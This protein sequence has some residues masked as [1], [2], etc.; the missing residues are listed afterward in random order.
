MYSPDSWPLNEKSD[1]WAVGLV[2]HRL[3]W[4]GKGNDHFNN[5]HLTQLNE[6]VGYR[7]QGWLDTFENAGL[8]HNLGSFVDKTSPYH[9]VHNNDLS[10]SD[11]DF[12]VAAYDLTNHEG[13]YSIELINFIHDCLNYHPD[14]RPDLYTMKSTIDTAISRLDELYGDE[15]RKPRERTAMGHTVLVE[16]ER[17]SAF[18][19]GQQ[20]EPPRK[21]R[22]VSVDPLTNIAGHDYNKHV[23]AWSDVSNYPRP[24]PE[25]QAEAIQAIEDFL[26]L[27]RNSH[28]FDED[29]KLRYCFQYLR[30]C[31]FQRVAPDAPTHVVTTWHAELT[32]SFTLY[33][34]KELLRLIRGYVIPRLLEKDDSPIE[35]RDAL[36]VL[37]HAAQWGG[38]LLDLD[39]EPKSPVLDDKTELHRGFRDW[40]MIDPFDKNRV[41]SDS[42]LQ[43][44]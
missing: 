26:N 20:Y 38:F 6:H 5:C 27:K 11:E 33:A 40:V 3:L 23:A 41:P 22:K 16:N 29:P 25:Q 19:I 17:W 44:Q 42:D 10:P 2:A 36:R 35:M 31:L 13:I 30:T 18:D 9:P 43:S 8:T 24:S 12:R 34:K 4:A 1:V 37:D 7:M 32:H 15:N 28:H 14:E 39:G 21:R